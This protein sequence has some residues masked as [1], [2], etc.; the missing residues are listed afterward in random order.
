MD[1]GQ[2]LPEVTLTTQ[3]TGSSAPLLKIVL[4][5]ALVLTNSTSTPK[6]GPAT[7]MLTLGHGEFEIEYLSLQGDVQA[8]WNVSA[9][10]RGA[11]PAISLP[12]LY[13]RGSVIPKQ[14]R[15]A[16]VRERQRTLNE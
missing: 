4:K 10:N 5:N 3:L 8:G 7:E 1:F 13:S 6:G 15:T 9:N 2:H 14:F 11:V 12:L 16:S